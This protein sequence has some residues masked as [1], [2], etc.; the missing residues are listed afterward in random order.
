MV[1]VVEK[2]RLETLR[3]Q[4]DVSVLESM[5]IG[6]S[7]YCTDHKRAQSLRSLTYYLKRSRSLGWKFTFRKMDNGW[8]IIRVD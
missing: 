7:I 2:V 6:D 4:K 1:L 3:L 8:R 5:D